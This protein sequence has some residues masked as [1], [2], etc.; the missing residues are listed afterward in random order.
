MSF[1][2]LRP[3]LLEYLPLY[4]SEQMKRHNVIPG[5]SGYAQA[6]DAI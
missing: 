5:I 3:L 1:I 6:M 4:S 2:G